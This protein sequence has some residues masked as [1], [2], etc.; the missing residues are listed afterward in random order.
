MCLLPQ[1]EGKK[2]GNKALQGLSEIENELTPA[3]HKP[4]Q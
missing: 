1:H 3:K 2:P 4:S